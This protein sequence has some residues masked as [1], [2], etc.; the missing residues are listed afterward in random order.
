M[1]DEVSGGQRHC[2]R[3]GLSRF[4]RRTTE[5]CRGFEL[6]FQLTVRDDRGQM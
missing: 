3:C 5:E 4:D 6:G 1:I 2:G